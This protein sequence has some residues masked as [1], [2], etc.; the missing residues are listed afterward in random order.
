MGEPA[1]AEL[2]TTSKP[3]TSEGLKTRPD[4]VV[5]SLPGAPA[6][7]KDM[8]AGAAEL[9][10]RLGEDYIYE[11]S[12]S[13]PAAFAGGRA[14]EERYERIANEVLEKLGDRKELV[15]IGHSM[16]GVEALMFL[17]KIKDDERFEGKKID[18]V[19]FSPINYGTEKW[20]GLWG[21]KEGTERIL[22]ERDLFESHIACPLPYEVAKE[23]SPLMTEGVGFA[24]LT[25]KDEWRT[26]RKNFFEEVVRRVE[27]PDRADSILKQI[28]WRDTLL[29]EEVLSNKEPSK[30][31]LEERAKLIAPY[32]PALMSAEYLDEDSKRLLSD[33][34]KPNKEPM[35]L[36]YLNPTFLKSLSP[37]VKEMFK[38]SYD[39][40]VN[41]LRGINIRLKLKDITLNTNLVYMQN[42]KFATQEQAQKVIEQVKVDQV[43][44][45]WALADSTHFTVSY[46]PGMMIDVVEEITKKKL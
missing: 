44:S 5:L 26:Q 39:G 9:K 3:N 12:I 22:A 27:T 25:I 21:W 33:I 10:K 11:E 13:T 28:N 19:V 4:F 20:K 24:E 2:E 15:V 36:N 40:F 18:L 46:Q 35:I 38:M 31:L 45:V 42:D 23:I 41:T 6:S 1:L 29:T 14:K 43:A 8:W 34:Y 30:I 7:G 32:V 16:G 37:Y 17:D